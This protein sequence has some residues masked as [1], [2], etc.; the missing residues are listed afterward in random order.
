MMRGLRRLLAAPVPRLARQTTPRLCSGLAQRAPSEPSLPDPPRA[1]NLPAPPDAPAAG[2]DAPAQETLVVAKQ[3]LQ[4]TIRRS[5][6]RERYEGVLAAFGEAR[7]LGVGL[8][9][10]AFSL[11]LSACIKLQPTPQVREAANAAYDF[12]AR[13]RA[14]PIE[15]F[16]R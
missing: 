8:D 16:H 7:R 13:S 1:L 3:R 6:S 14:V 2:S 12:F 4:E 9:S 10:E 11:V 5:S 15:V